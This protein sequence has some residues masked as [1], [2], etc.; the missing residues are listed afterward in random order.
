M[1]E[2]SLLLFDTCGYRSAQFSDFRDDFFAQQ[3]CLLQSAMSFRIWKCVSVWSLFQNNTLFPSGFVV[4]KGYLL[5]ILF[6]SLYLFILHFYLMKWHLM[7][8]SLIVYHYWVVLDTYPF[9]R[10]CDVNCPLRLS[11]TAK[12]PVLFSLRFPTQ[13]G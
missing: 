5:I 10:F 7:L 12:L 2:L 4:G 1:L 8:L 9:L 3:N 11:W 6:C 13:Q